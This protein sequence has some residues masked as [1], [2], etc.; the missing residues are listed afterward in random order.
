MTDVIIPRYND[1]DELQGVE[2]TF[3][4]VNIH[5]FEVVEDYEGDDLFSLTNPPV[6]AFIIPPKFTPFDSEVKVA[7]EMYGYPDE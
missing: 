4:N 1:D 6:D 7:T 5:E 3:E 2:V